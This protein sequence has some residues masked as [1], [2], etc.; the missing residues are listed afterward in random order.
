MGK[1]FKIIKNYLITKESPM[2][3]CLNKKPT[4]NKKKIITLNAK[5]NESHNIRS[6]FHIFTSSVDENF[7]LLVFFCYRFGKAAFN[8][9]RLHM[10]LALHELSCAKWVKR[11]FFSYY[12]RTNNNSNNNSR[13]DWHDA[14]ICLCNIDLDR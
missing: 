6:L 10:R 13:T 7:V 11:I 9:N 12:I 3:F 5:K 4:T 14:R 8:V 1:S 2:P